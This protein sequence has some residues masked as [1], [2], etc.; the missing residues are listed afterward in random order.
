MCGHEQFKL[1]FK[2]AARHSCWLHLAYTCRTSAVI[3]GIGSLVPLISLFVV[4]H[5]EYRGY[6]ELDW[7]KFEHLF[8][9]FGFLIG[10]A[11]ITG[12]IA[13]N[14]LVIGQRMIYQ[15]LN[16]VRYLR[17]PR[18]FYD[19]TGRAVNDQVCPECGEFSPRR[20]CVRLW[21]DLLRSKF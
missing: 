11:M 9:P 3:T 17:C 4:S 16:D 7:L 2:H 20:E 21:C 5:L 10:V 8:Y 12:F 18:C 1:T 15:K 19:L 14:S 13:I 6:I